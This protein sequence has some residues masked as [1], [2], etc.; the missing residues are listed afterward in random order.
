MRTVPNK[1]VS[2]VSFS[3]IC[4]LVP[5]RSSRAQMNIPM[6]NIDVEAEKKKGNIIKESDWKITIE[7]VKTASSLSRERIIGSRQKTLAPKNGAFVLVTLRAISTKKKGNFPNF[8][9]IHAEIYLVDKTGKNWSSSGWFQEGNDVVYD[10]WLTGVV[11][12]DYVKYNVY[13]DAPDR[14]A[15][16]KLHVSDEYPLLELKK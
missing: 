13:F 9:P 16:F 5:F 6:E 11:T 3:L 4:L 14:I 1:L 2:T 10:T 7:S 15:D 12:Q 8:Y